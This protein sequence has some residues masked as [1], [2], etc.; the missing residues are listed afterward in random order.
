MAFQ[1]AVQY[2]L[3]PT[4]LSTRNGIKFPQMG[5]IAGLFCGR[6]RRSVKKKRSLLFHQ[7]IDN[8][9]IHLQQPRASQE[10]FLFSV[11]GLFNYQ[12]FFIG[13]WIFKRGWIFILALFFSVVGNY[14]CDYEKNKMF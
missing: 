14:L 3:P 10:T 12:W 2:R 7:I 1:I 11:Y 9:L 6:Q 8:Q 4:I 5:A 13:Y